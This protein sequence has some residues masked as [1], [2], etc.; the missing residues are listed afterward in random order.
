LTIP[1]NMTEV[2]SNWLSEKL[3]AIVEIRSATQIGQ[4]VGLMGDIFRVE[5]DC[6]NEAANIPSSVVVKLPSSFE[7]NRA[8]GVALGMFEA[9]VRFYQSL[10]PKAPV[11]LPKIFH[12]EI[13]PGSADF[14]IIMED[15]SRLTL[16]SQT[17]G[18]SA[19]QAEAAVR[20]LASIHAVW[21]GKVQVPELEWIL[22][23]TGPRIEYVD[24]LLEQILPVFLEGFGHCLPPGGAELYQRFAG[25]YLNFNTTLAK[26][27]PWTLAHQDY[28]VENLM[29]GAE[30]TGEV[31]VID[32]QGIGRGPGAYDLAYL[33]GGSL[34][35]EVR[36]QHESDLVTIYHEELS[37][38][39]V[40]DYSL[41]QAFDDYGF[42]HL[43]GG[44]ATAMV[45]G[46]SMDLSNERG[47]QLVETMA[48]RHITAALDHHG[49]TL[50]D[51]VLASR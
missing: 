30:D 40:V 38:N 6:Q 3:G 16:V 12:A 41:K 39:G 34:D 4:G 22:A 35:I 21:W 49:L 33:L 43:M 7:E 26:R 48:S 20:V 31:M 27:S 44:L 45:T 23:M 18:M 10:A 5:L 19:G 47:K 11:G 2:T 36:R 25:N 42:A 1:K 37:R 9:E 14:V 29:F 51:Q 17:E 50:A 24:Q 28:R 15:L 32:W 13:E 8:Q 46:G